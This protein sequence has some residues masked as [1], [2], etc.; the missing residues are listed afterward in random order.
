MGAGIAGFL[1]LNFRPEWIAQ[2][3]GT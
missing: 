2:L 1:G 3:L